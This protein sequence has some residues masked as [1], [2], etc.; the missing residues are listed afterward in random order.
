[1]EI[2]DTLY[3]SSRDDWH[4]WLAAHHADRSEI[5]L[6]GYRNSTEKPSVPY[7][8]AVEEALCFGWIDSIRKRLDD[9]SY[10]QRYSPR[11]PGSPYSQTNLERLAR[12]IER[13]RV[14][15][16]V[17]SAPGEV[18]PEAYRVPQDIEAALRADP[19]AWK[20]W[21]SFSA[22]YRRIRAA[23]VDSA[24]DRVPE[25]FRKR[26]DHLVRKTAEGKQFGYHIE[27]FY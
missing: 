20:H 10:A 16:S 27:D 14:A 5:W 21:R 12:L 26:L 2:S 7:N 24:R 25:E 1:M 15:P 13:G 19:A 22:P 18:R 9:E 3:A 8:E 17:L 23:Y 6:V 11:R 4:R